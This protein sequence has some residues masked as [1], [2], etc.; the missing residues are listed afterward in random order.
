MTGHGAKGLI[1]VEIVLPRLLDRGAGLFVRG[2]VGDLMMA[3]AVEGDLA[4]GAAEEA[5][6]AV[7]D[8]A[9]SGGEALACDEARHETVADGWW[10]MGGGWVM[11]RGREGEGDH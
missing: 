9:G 8:C 11:G 2:P 7:A 10:W 4:G 6:S 3:A 1:F 5:V